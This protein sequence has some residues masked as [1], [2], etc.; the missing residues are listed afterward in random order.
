MSEPRITIK[1]WEEY[2][3]TTAMLLGWDDYRWTKGK[4]SSKWRRAMAYLEENK[5]MTVL[6]SGQ[7]VKFIPP[8][9]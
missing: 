3:I 8:K 9:E 2:V 1:Q 6:I 4:E 7:I 5:G